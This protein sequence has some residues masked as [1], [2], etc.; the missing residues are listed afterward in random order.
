[1][2]RNVALYLD[3][4]VIELCK[5]KGINI[6][7]TCNNIL[8]QELELKPIKKSEALIQTL[9][10]KNVKLLNSISD[11]R[12]EYE[13]VLTENK[14]LKEKVEKL[15]EKLKEKAQRAIGDMSGFVKPY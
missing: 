8:L 9:K 1:M 6:S 12:A 11:L 14:K 10:M 2:K 3:I 7:S 13:K 15:N 5:K 4:D